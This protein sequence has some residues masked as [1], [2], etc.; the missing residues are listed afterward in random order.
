MI[1]DSLITITENRPTNSSIIYITVSDQD[2]GENGRI[3]VESPIS[4]N[5]FQLNQISNNTFRISS[6]IRFD[7][8]SQS[9]YSFSLIIYDH[10]KPSH[11]IIKKFELIVLDLNDCFPYFHSSV[12]STFEIDENNAKNFVVETIRVF[13]DDENDRIR[14]FVDKYEDFFSI[15]EE[16]QLIIRES[17]DFERE[18]IYELN[19]IA[20]DLVGHRTNF[21][22][23]IFVRNLNDNPVEFRNHFLEILLRINQPIGSL[24]SQI[25]AKDKDKIGEI[26]Y[27]IDI[28]DRERVQN[29]IELKSNGQLLT[30]NRFLSMEF[31]RFRFHVVANDS[32]FIDKILVQIRISNQSI[33]KPQSPVYFHKKSNEPMF[34]HLQS[35]RNRS[36]SMRNPSSNDLILYPNGTLI[37]QSNRRTSSLDIYLHDDDHCLIFKD[38]LLIN[39][40]ESLWTLAFYLFWMIFIVCLFVIL[41]YSQEKQPKSTSSSTTYMKISHSFDDEL[42]F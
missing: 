36:F 40:S 5:V 8:E 32:K 33:V 7:R 27:S 39:Q 25:S 9:K 31:D 6:K 42:L 17:L 23:T 37:V 26:I 24:F 2:S 21:S 3:S 38:F 10:G 13:D 1:N 20:E 18:S 14:L 16:N 4:T 12:N 22:I 41:L 35:D 28:N 29:L 11:S 15:N 19:L 30:K 34:I